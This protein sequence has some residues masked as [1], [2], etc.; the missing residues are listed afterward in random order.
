MEQT[1]NKTQRSLGFK[2]LSL[3]IN[4][5]FL[6]HLFNSIL[7]AFSIVSRREVPIFFPDISLLI[8]TIPYLFFY[9][10]S[11]LGLFMLLKYKQRRKILLGTDYWLAA[12][13]GTKYIF[14]IILVIFILFILWIFSGSSL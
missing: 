12:L 6:L 2:I 14:I 7:F 4:G 10:L 8:F 9:F 3:C 5:L 1:S 11:D 13:L